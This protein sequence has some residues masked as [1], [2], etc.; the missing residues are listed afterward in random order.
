MLFDNF[1]KGTGDTYSQSGLARKLMGKKNLGSLFNITDD[2]EQDEEQPDDMSGNTPS[3]HT[4]EETP[5]GAA[6]GG[7]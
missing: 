4:G 3:A 1:Q 6:Q 5:D 2:H 7:W